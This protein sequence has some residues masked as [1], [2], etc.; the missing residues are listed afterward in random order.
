MA[1][2]PLDNKASGLMAG[3]GTAVA[4]VATPIALVALLSVLVL[5]YCKC[6]RG[7]RHQNARHISSMS[8]VPMVTMARCNRLDSFPS[9]AMPPA[10]SSMGNLEDGA[11][12][13]ARVGGTSLPYR[14]FRMAT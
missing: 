10:M 5:A 12:S 13:T 4:S 9:L 6:V 3:S 8:G 11:H 1:L 2:A 7:K 14:A